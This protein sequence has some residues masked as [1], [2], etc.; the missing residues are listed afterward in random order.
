MRTAA[1][2]FTGLLLGTSACSSDDGGGGGDNPPTA[3]ANLGVEKLG[4]GGHLTWDDS[5]TEEEYMIMRK[6]GTDSYI[7]LGSVTFNTLQYHDEPLT[8]GTSYTYMVMAINAAGQS[9]SD[10]VTYVHQ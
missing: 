4:G 7:E 5:D 2:I 10:E 6:E 9:E 3:P 1:I 8:V